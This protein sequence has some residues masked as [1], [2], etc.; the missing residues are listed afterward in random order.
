MKTSSF[1]PEP[2][3]PAY[4]RLRG[5]L[6][7]SSWICHGSLVCRPLIRRVAGR[8]VNKGPYYLWTAKVRSKTV[9]VSLSKA[10]YQYLAQAIANNRRIQKT[11]QRMQQLTLKTILKK[12]PGVKKRK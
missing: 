4:E 9:C 6:A 10:Q 12:V 3:P 1:R 11:L 2:L 7:Q 5:E 8:K